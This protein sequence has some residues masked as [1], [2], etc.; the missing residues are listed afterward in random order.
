MHA[1]VYRRPCVSGERGQAWPLDERRPTSSRPLRF[2]GARD[3]VRSML[4]VLSAS[5]F[6]AEQVCSVST[7]IIQ[8]CSYGRI[9]GVFML[10]RQRGAMRSTR[11]PVQTTATM[12]TGCAAAVGVA[13]A[14]PLHGLVGV[15]PPTLA[16]STW[17]LLTWPDACAQDS[18][19][20]D[21]S[22]VSCDSSDCSQCHCHGRMLCCQRRS[23]S[24][25]ST[26][27]LV[28]GGLRTRRGY[29]IVG[30]KRLIQDITEPDAGDGRASADF[31]AMG[32][33]ADDTLASNSCTLH[34]AKRGPVESEDSALHRSAG[35]STELA[36]LDS[37]ESPSPPSVSGKETDSLASARPPSGG[38]SVT[39]LQP[40]PRD[41]HAA[42]SPGACV[43]PSSQQSSAT[44]LPDDARAAGPDTEARAQ[45]AS[46]RSRFAPPA[47]DAAHGRDDCGD[48]DELPDGAD[49]R[50]G[51]GDAS[52]GGEGRSLRE[53]AA[54]QH[55]S[56]PGSRGRRAHADIVCDVQCSPG[57]DLIAT[58]GVGKQASLA[59]KPH[60]LTSFNVFPP[61]RIVCCLAT[62]PRL[63]MGTRCLHR[64]VV[65]CC[66]VSCMVPD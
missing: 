48:A 19:G 28:L 40:P 30:R 58:A 11:P 50:S 56:L 10:Q 15:G 37:P 8:W 31:T 43:L 12:R 4:A 49:A 14:L 1:V 23:I 44:G 46:S 52:G 47:A 42:L 38:Q 45:Q 5:P 9:A 63:C 29:S 33:H 65:A 21:G 25:Q 22:P 24:S 66:T 27:Q 64:C 32:S 61:A 17:S 18:D 57:G 34:R 54:F 53:V 41:Q 7:P 3:C 2:F 26:G 36:A 35:S 59:R 51:D 39:E 20:S 60:T 55:P 13:R 16:T 62:L 6:S